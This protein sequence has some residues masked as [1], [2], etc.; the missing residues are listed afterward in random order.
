MAQARRLWRTV[1]G[2]PFLD[3]PR[4][5]L[6]NRKKRGK[7]MAT[8]PRDSKGRFRKRKSAGGGRKKKRRYTGKTRVVRTKARRVVVVRNPR[9]RARRR[10]SAAANPPRRRRRSYRKNPTRIFGKFFSMPTLRAVGFTV[11]GVT[12]TPFIEGFVFRMLPAQFQNKW[13]R[14]AVQIGSVWGVGTLTGRFFGKEA[15]RAAYIG[16]AAYVGLGLIREF[17]PGVLGTNALGRY[18][19]VG[20]QPLIGAYPGMGTF[21]TAGAPERLQPSSRF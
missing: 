7:K 6:A 14:Y 16:G 15:G 2:E 17:F 21:A 9:K 4:L 1:D 11:L 12:A 10:T 13:V 18:T 3:N 20:A 5:M 8:P 19:G